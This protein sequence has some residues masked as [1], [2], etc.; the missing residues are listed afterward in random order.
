MRWR[1]RVARVVA[2]AVLS[3]AV[4]VFGV[5]SSP[6]GADEIAGPPASGDGAYVL[7]SVSGWQTGSDA[8]H[9][10]S[11]EVFGAY[12]VCNVKSPGSYGYA[13]YDLTS[14]RD[15]GYLHVGF[16]TP[17]GYNEVDVALVSP[18]HSSA[19]ATVASYDNWV[20]VEAGNS[21]TLAFG[22]SVQIDSTSDELAAGRLKLK[23]QMTRTGDWGGASVA[24]SVAS[25]VTGSPFSK[26]TKSPT[27]APCGLGNLDVAWW[28]GDAH[29]GGDG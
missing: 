21:C 20:R 16:S 15:V 24:S 11:G 2:V 19:C 10:E 7:C 1:R 3:A 29:N 23:W 5:A 13:A 6:A 28:V 27:G 9:W 12:L 4:G 8:S 18:A 25:G 14:G 22:R 26:M 17:V